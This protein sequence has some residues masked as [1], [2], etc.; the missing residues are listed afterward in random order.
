MLVKKEHRGIFTDDGL[1]SICFRLLK[2]DNYLLCVKH[3]ENLKS[4]F[5]FVILF[6]RLYAKGLAHA[7]LGVLITQ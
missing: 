4:T 5:H 6:Y 1:S 7:R 3:I 2:T